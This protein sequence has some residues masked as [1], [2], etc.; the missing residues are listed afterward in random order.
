MKKYLVDTSAL[1]RYILKDIPSQSGVVA[2][3]FRQAKNGQSELTMP[4]AVFF[5][6]TYVLTAVYKFGRQAVK[7]QCEKF[8]MIPYLDIPER[9]ALR[10]GYEIWVTHASISFADAV[11]FHMAKLGEKELF[12]LDKKLKHLAEDGKITP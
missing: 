11:L 1:L 5:E 4:L 12:T 6:A 7:T 2:E 8:L 9:A 3:V 10:G